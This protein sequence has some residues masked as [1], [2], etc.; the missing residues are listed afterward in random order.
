[1][2]KKLLIAGGILAAAVAGGAVW[3][4]L[5][6]GKPQTLAAYWDGESALDQPDK[7]GR[8]PL[9]R[10][11][12]A[13]DIDVAKYLVAA[14]A[15]TDK[16]DRNGVSA[17]ALA[18][19]SGNFNLFEAVAAGHKGN[20]KAPELM[21]KALDG[22]NLKI[23]QALLDK[24]SDANAVLLFKGKHKPDDM[25]DMT[26][27]RVVTPLKKAVAAER[28][29]IAAALLDKGADGA[30]YFLQ[31][32]VRTGKPELVRVLGDKAGDLRAL[33]IKNMDLLTYAADKAPLATLSYLI[34]KNA[35]DINLALQQVLLYRKGEADG[36]KADAAKGNGEAEEMAAGG[37]AV[38]ER[39]AEDKK[40]A[41]AAQ[42]GGEAGV[43]AVSAEGKAAAAELLLQRGA[44]PTAEAMEMMLARK[45]PDIYLALAKCMPNP[46]VAA[47]GKDS[48]LIYAIEH[49]YTDAV[50]YLLE[51][52][53]DIWL[54]EAGG[55]MPLGEAIR[56]AK[57]YPELPPLFEKKLKGPN[58]QGYEGE[59]ALMLYAKAGDEPA[60]MRLVQ[61]G[62]DIFLTDNAGRTLLMYA[63]EG[64]NDKIMAHLL[65]NGLNVAAKD[66]AGR[67]A[68]MYAAG[69]GHDAMVAS[70][71]EKGAKAVD[72][73]YEGKTALMYAA[74]KCRPETLRLFLD[75]GEG[76]IKTD[77]KQRT[78]LMYAAKSG[79]VPAAAFL[80]EQN[81]D[82]GQF[83]ADDVSVLAYA[84]QSG[85][86]EM[87]KLIL[88]YGGDVYATDKFGR[89]PLL[90]AVQKGNEAQ[91]DLL[92][93]VHMAYTEVNRKNGKTV[94]M[95]ASA[96]ENAE[97]L[98]RVLDGSKPVLNRKD[99]QG[100]TAL[101]YAVNKGRPDIIRDFLRKGA[102]PEARDNAGKTVLMYAAE[103]MVSVNMVTVLHRLQGLHS[104]IIHMRDNDGK[105]AL[106]YAADGKYSQ[107]IK[108][109]MLLGTD[110]D[111]NVAD[112]TG[113][114]A[115]MYA[116]GNAA[117]RVDIKMAEELLN[118]SKDV[119][120]KDD[121][122][123]TAL[124][125]AAENP[126]AG[127]R[128]L[129]MLIAKG[130]DVNAADNNGKTVLMYAAAGGDIGKVRLL[131]DAGAKTGAKT[132]DGKT[133]ADFAKSCGPCFVNA[134]KG[135]WK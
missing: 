69:A 104:P 10:A 29:D 3:V 41:D 25:P 88:T 135:L 11:V 36:D 128:I 32:V 53:A 84:A 68:L 74:E 24:G 15:D 97:I 132:Q 42:P 93:S 85:N 64:G 77:N 101:M 60:F 78:A 54:A 125:Y 26:D 13:G 80:L 20:F 4:M 8:L 6:D 81:N 75:N 115:L 44:R 56:L 94:L 129:D 90:Y 17:L 124:M 43:S 118:A 47:N 116:V 48:M 72:A 83:D 45:Q 35:G 111:A 61:G 23:V 89:L 82:V 2:N 76:V 21:D 52:G 19:G 110:M 14:G 28:A 126:N 130:A 27:P 131:I 121:N 1:M 7:S 112:N 59:T 5:P 50:E 119:N 134:T 70:L 22:G 46:N 108:V 40:A 37:N 57:K 109:H 66:N 92:N 51:Q 9:L 79:N 127:S 95:Y 117:V 98:R 120:Q 67:T 71:L 91:F 103:G 107:L 73:D 18:A 102:N 38:P 133:A 113:K 30:G 123:R 63:A 39:G 33:E 96:G 65:Y 16:K 122:G 62:G 49:G 55:K 105:T 12:E 100:R 31:Q 86:A 34:D 58:E 87:I 99:R 114:T 106:M